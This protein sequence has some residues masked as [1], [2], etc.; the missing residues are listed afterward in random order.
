MKNTLWKRG[1]ESMILANSV[2]AD[3]CI[4]CSCEKIIRK[5]DLKI[6]IGTIEEKK[7]SGNTL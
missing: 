4:E 1:Y 6:A 5:G 3:H 7:E 2:N